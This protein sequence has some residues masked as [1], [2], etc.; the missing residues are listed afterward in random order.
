MTGMTGVERYWQRWRYSF[1]IL[2]ICVSFTVSLLLIQDEADSRVNGICGALMQVKEGA[3][4]LT[5]PASAAGVTDP[6]TL[7]RIKDAN[8]ARQHA[9][10]KLERS[11]ACRDD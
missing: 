1:S 7:Q 9:R 8:T 4:E 11:L 5:Q 2:L 6:A 3:L 10:A